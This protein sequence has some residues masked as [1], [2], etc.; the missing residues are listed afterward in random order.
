MRYCHL[1]RSTNFRT[2][3][4]FQIFN[5]FTIVITTYSYLP[6]AIPKQDVSFIVCSLLKLDASFCPPFRHC[7][8]D[9]SH[10]SGFST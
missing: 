2:C 5:L 6:I 1:L 9:G 7:C 10:S 3:N 4:D 8:F